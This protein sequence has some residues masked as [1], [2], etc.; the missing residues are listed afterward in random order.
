MKRGDKYIV[1]IEEVFDNVARIKGLGTIVVEAQLDELEK[2]EEEEIEEEFF[3]VGDEVRNIFE[4]T[5]WPDL[6]VATKIR[7]DKTFCG[8]DEEGETYTMLSTEIYEPTGKNY[9]IE[10][11][12]K[13]MRIFCGADCTKMCYR[14]P[15]YVAE[16]TRDFW[17]FKDECPDFKDEWYDLV[18]DERERR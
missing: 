14:N 10:D 3:G 6:V 15:L 18:A 5:P 16:D 4:G 9:G 2:Y 1:E 11:V 17:D 12:L 8:F 13:D 7:D